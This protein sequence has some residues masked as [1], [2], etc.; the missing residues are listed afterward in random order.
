[1]VERQLP[2]LNAKGSNPFTRFGEEQAANSI[3]SWRLFSV[4]PNHI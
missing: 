2:K 3:K 1:V 4:G